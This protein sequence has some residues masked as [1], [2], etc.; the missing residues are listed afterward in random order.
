MYSD[1]QSNTTNFKRIFNLG[2]NC[3]YIYIYIV[4]SYDLGIEEGKE[5]R[6]KKR[7]VFAAKWQWFNRLGNYSFQ[8]LPLEHICNS[9]AHFL[10]G[11]AKC[12]FNFLFSQRQHWQVDMALSAQLNAQLLKRR[13]WSER[14]NVALWISFPEIESEELSIGTFL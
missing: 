12:S 4:L 10:I 14:Q 2:V 8:M 13:I 9:C 6:Y 3:S 5:G 11:T 7:C 1:L